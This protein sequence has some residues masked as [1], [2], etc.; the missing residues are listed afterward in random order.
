VNKV[1]THPAA[2]EVSGQELGGARK[3]I[4]LYRLFRFIRNG[5]SAETALF[6]CCV[7]ARRLLNRN[8]LLAT[9]GEADGW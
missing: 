5:R 6:Y 8:Y 3:N 4:V 1:C 7:V 9:C 2:I